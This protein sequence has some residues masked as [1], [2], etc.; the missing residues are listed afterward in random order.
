MRLHI[1]LAVQSHTFTLSEGVQ[2]A[3]SLPG[4]NAGLDTHAFVPSNGWSFSAPPVAPSSNLPELTPLALQNHTISLTCSLVGHLNG[5]L[6]KTTT[7]QI[8][9]QRVMLRGSS[10]THRVGHP[11]LK[12]RPRSWLTRPMNSASCRLICTS[13]QVAAVARLVTS[14]IMTASC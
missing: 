7:S 3:C 11:H 4:F 14:V 8:H 1:V 9:L 2:T 5:K 12:V 13:L 6:K 10:S